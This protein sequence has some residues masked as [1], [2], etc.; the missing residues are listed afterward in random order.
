MVN[1]Y[2]EGNATYAAG[3]ACD[4]KMDCRFTVSSSILG[5]PANGCGKD[6]SLEYRCRP[7]K[8]IKTLKLPAEANNEVAALD[9]REPDAR[10]ESH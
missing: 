6:F 1:S 9:C 3:E 10:A 2:R 4:G 5:D 7:G 8:S